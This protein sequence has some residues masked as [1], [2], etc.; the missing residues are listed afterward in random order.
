MITRGITPVICWKSFVTSRLANSFD[1]DGDGAINGVLL[2]Q[3]RQDFAF[4][5]LAVLVPIGAIP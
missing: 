3:T 2:I 5:S 1:M 4:D